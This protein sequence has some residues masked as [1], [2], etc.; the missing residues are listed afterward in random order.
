MNSLNTSDNTDEQWFALEV[1]CRQEKAIAENLRSKGYEAFAPS[2][3][4]RRKWHNRV[5]E[6]ETPLFPGYVFGK[7]DARFRLPILMTPGVRSVVGYGR[8]PSP[9]DPAEIDAVRNVL[10]A[11]LSVERC[12]YFAEG[13]RVRIVGGPLAGVTGILL[14]HRSS[15]R[16]VL[17]VSLIQQSIRVEVDSEILIAEPAH[18]RPSRLSLAS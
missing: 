6:V 15:Y 9:L 2:S 12:P 4:T 7:F 5:Q 17:S 11:Q 16:V 13:D 1:K 10:L 14:K 18:D 8:V 3:H